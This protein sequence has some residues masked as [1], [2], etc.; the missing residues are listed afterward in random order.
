MATLTTTARGQV[1]FRKEVFQYL[2][3]EPGQKIELNKLPDGRFELSASK[4]RGDIQDFFGVLKGKSKKI[5]SL[6]EIN[7]AASGGWDDGR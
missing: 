4:P 7:N 1:T 6:Q 5:A 3:I 2:G